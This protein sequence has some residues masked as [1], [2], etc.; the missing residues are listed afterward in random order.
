MEFPFDFSH[1][2]LDLDAIIPKLAELSLDD[3]KAEIS[4]PR[5]FRPNIFGVLHG[6]TKIRVRDGIRQIEKD[7]RSALET[8]YKKQTKRP[9]KR[10][11]GAIQNTLQ[12]VAIAFL[13]RV[14]FLDMYPRNIIIE[15]AIGVGKTFTT[16]HLRRLFISISDKSNIRCIQEQY[17]VKLL[18]QLYD[19]PAKTFY[20]FQTQVIDL[21]HECYRKYLLL[22]PKNCFKALQ[23]FERSPIG[24]LVF[25]RVGKQYDWLT[26]EQYKRLKRDY[27][28]L[29]TEYF[30]DICTNRIY[31]LRT[32][33]SIIWK[34]I[35]SRNR[36]EEF[37]ANTFM[38]KEYSRRV[39]QA[40][41]HIMGKLK[42]MSTGLD[43]KT[44]DLSEDIGWYLTPDGSRYFIEKF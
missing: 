14:K 38:S 28:A 23:I 22:T 5:T 20:L 34:R 39:C 1:I 33:H 31:Y 32:H 36:D 15:G 24:G 42:L 21:L 26:K 7:S 30:N 8:L 16:N 41:D 12:T 6:R 3:V 10:R 4:N 13:I 40:Y 18:G 43:I 44:I 25:I 9:K 19:D 27:T 11:F 17:P 37:S 35:E 2:D 29:L